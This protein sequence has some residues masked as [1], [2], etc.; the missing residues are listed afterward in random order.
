MVTTM[1]HVVVVVVVVVGV[2][3]LFVCLYVFA[4]FCFVCCFVFFVVFCLVFV[5]VCLFVFFSFFFFVFF[6]CLFIF[7]QCP[8]KTI[9]YTNCITMIVGINRMVILQS[10]GFLVLFG[11]IRH[12]RLTADLLKGEVS[13]LYQLPSVVCNN[14]LLFHILI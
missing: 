1:A 8:Y 3:F 7:L 12:N 11:V 14:C 6:F 13:L 5:F 10:S 9:I 4:L 2:G